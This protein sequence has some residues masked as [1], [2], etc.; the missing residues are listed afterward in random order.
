MGQFRFELEALLTYRRHQLEQCRRL[1]AEVLA[2]QQACQAERAEWAR[3]RTQLEGDIRQQS[4]AGRVDISRMAAQR[5]YL[6]QLDVQSLQLQARETRIVQQ[7]ELCRQAVLQA[8]R[9]VRALEQLR[10]KRQHDFQQA[11]F[12]REQRE[13]EE[14]WTAIRYIGGN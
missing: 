11:E 10:E 13:L 9:A 12:K 7:L 1:M 2:D 5:Y 14:S 3:E 8:D 6:T 4:L